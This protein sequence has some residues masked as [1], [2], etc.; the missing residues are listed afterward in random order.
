MSNTEPR[1]SNAQVFGCIVI[2]AGPAGLIASATAAQNGM[3]TL[4]L[5][6]N[7][8]IGRKLALTGGGRCNITN[9][10]PPNDFLK[11]LGPNGQFLRSALNAFDST[12]LTE[13]LTEIGITLLADG[14]Q[15]FVLGGARKLIDAIS[16]Y[17]RRRSVNVSLNQ[18]VRKIEKLSDGGFRITTATDTFI[19]DNRVIIAAGGRS[20]PQTGSNGDGFEL[21]RMLGHD[22]VKP[23]PAMGPVRLTGS[24][25]PGLSGI[26]TDSVRIELSDEK[27]HLATFEG[28]MLITHHG[29]SGPPILDASL[30]IARTLQDDR[31]PK[32]KIDFL[33]ETPTDQLTEQLKQSPPDMTA[34][35]NIPTRLKNRLLE[36]SSVNPGST[37]LTRPQRRRLIET[38]K[39]LTLP[40]A[41]TGTWQQAMVTVGGVS[42]KQV[43]PRTMQSRITPE[44]YFAGEVLDIAANCGGFNIQ[45]AISTAHLAA[46]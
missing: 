7:D 29:L 14:Q 17:L 38:L 20:Y 44:I 40:I 3:K 19:S 16:H 6:K 5:D 13:F 22:I 1:Y 26:T 43:D 23:I 42:L 8:H 10:L 2:G 25:F 27:K 46:S 33:P 21:A 45:S 12:Q 35:K 37:Q 28:Q 30:V 9:T 36:L 4:L 31:S 34:L 15:R 39:S 24:V 32:L 41:D 11:A 18:H